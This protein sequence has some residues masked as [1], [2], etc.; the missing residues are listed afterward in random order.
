MIKSRP[1]IACLLLSLLSIGN[2]LACKCKELSRDSLV[3]ISMRGSDVVFLGELVSFPSANTFTFKIIEQFKGN[4]TDS[5]IHGR[6]YD[7]CSVHP[8]GEGS[9]IIYANFQK[10]SLIR[11]DGCGPSIHYSEPGGRFLPPGFY[12]RIL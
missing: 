5:L 2:V 9:W 8:K 1:W 10:D 4:H 7:L 12:W 6:T 11:I 3:S